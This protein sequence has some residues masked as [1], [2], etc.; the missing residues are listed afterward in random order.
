MFISGYILT[1]GFGYITLWLFH[2]N[3][4]DL[5]YIGGQTYADGYL[6]ISI[7]MMTISAF[8][9]LMRSGGIEKIG[10]I[11]VKKPVMFIAGLSFAMYL[12]HLL[13]IDTLSKFYGVTPDSPS[14]PGLGGYLLIST[15][16]TFSITIPLAFIIHKTPYLRKI[17]GEK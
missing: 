4:S 14:M 6:S 1:I 17:V 10:S 9:L 16:L 3:I 2:H 13:V 8:N 11:W 7:I 12:N 5:F 15:F